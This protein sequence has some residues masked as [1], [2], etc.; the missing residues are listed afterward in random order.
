M[1]RRRFDLFTAA[2]VGAL[3]LVFLL[4]GC[5]LLII[6]FRGAAALPAHLASQQTLFALG[7]SVKSA[8]LSTLFCFLLA[9]PAAYVLTRV[10]LPF[11]GVIEG[12]L[13]LSMSLPYIVLGLSLL[14]LFSS[15]MGKALSAA[16][17][18]VVFSQ[19]GIVIAQ[20]VVNLPFAIRLVVTAFH[21]VDQKLER[22]AGLLG[23]PPAKRF[24]SILL[25]LSRHGLISAFVLIWSR[26]LGEFGATLMLV[27]V[28]RLKTETLPGNIYL[29]VS[30]NHIDSALASAFL[31]LVLSG[32]SLAISAWMT[33]ADRRKDRYATD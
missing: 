19:N 20:L 18:P 11:R 1:N 26:A 16:G 32:I 4:M 21:G 3:L 15:P 2:C 13:E 23:A 29:N 10:R 5:V 12:L 27:G 8:S 30:T 33:K 14:I 7:L 28:T 31:L 9:V 6:V 24:S 17:F 25:P 22:V